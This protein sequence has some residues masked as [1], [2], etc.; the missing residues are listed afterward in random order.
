ARTQKAHRAIRQQGVCAARV[1]AIDLF[2]VRAVDAT[3]SRLLGTI[4]ARTLDPDQ[5]APTGP[6]ATSAHVTGHRPAGV[7]DLRQARILRDQDRLGRAVRDVRDAAHDVLQHDAVE[8][9]HGIDQT[10]ID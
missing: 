8:V 3:R 7:P 10:Q 2:L 4:L 5:A 9:S 1:E 6:T